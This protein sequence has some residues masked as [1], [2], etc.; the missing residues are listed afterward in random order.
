MGFSKDSK[1]PKN[2]MAGHAR[3]NLIQKKFCV[4]R[5][6]DPDSVCDWITDNRSQAGSRGK[7]SRKKA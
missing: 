1:C 5:K 4:M 7:M 6:P 2:K 3:E